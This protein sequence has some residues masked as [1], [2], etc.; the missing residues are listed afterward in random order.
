MTEGQ[1]GRIAKLQ[2]RAAEPG[3]DRVPWRALSANLDVMRSRLGEHAATLGLAVDGW[4]AA[5]ED[6][7]PSD[8]LAALT[9]LHLEERWDPHSLRRQW[10]PVGGAEARGLVSSIKGTLFEQQV[11]ERAAAGDLPLPDGGDHMRLADDLTEPGW[12]AEVLD[13]EDVVGVVQMKATGSVA[14]LVDH[15]ERYPD[16]SDVITTSEVAK[17][18]AE[19]GVSVLDSGIANDEL[20]DVLHDAVESLDA[21]SAVHEVLPVVGLGAVAVRAVLA[22]RRG[23]SNEEVA[24]L[25][26]EEGVALIAINA[27][28][29]IVE[30]STGTVL[31][32]PVTTTAIRLGLHRVRVQRRVAGQLAR[33]AC[34]LRPLRERC[35]SADRDGGLATPAPSL[36]S[37]LSGVGRHGRE[38][39]HVASR[40]AE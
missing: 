35:A 37:R 17:E 23:A 30:T 25:L 22:L 18:A 8:V 5:A 24:A 2:M 39:I 20:A 6:R 32:R 9:R 27:A 14:Y 34:A 21:V 13:G 15:L 28:G 38:P 1:A 31:L 12:D 40:L 11:V 10:D 26:R 3:V 29:L 4:R 33:Q 36:E 19:R 16:I 7:W